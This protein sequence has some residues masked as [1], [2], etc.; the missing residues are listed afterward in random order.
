MLQKII[1]A[2]LLAA[3]VSCSSNTEQSDVNDT[4]SAAVDGSDEISDDSFSED[5]L[6]GNS[7]EEQTVE[8]ETD[9]IDAAEDNFESQETA[10]LD[11]AT[12]DEFSFDEDTNDSFSADNLNEEADAAA[13]S[14]A[15]LADDANTPSDSTD[16][17]SQE[18]EDYFAEDAGAGAGAVAATTDASGPKANVTKLDFLANQNGGTIVITT[19]N[20]V[21]YTTRSNPDSKQF[22]IEIPNANLPKKFQRPYNTNEFKGAIGLFQGYQNPDGNVA[23]FVVQMDKDGEPLVQQE[24]NS[25]MIIA[26]G[27]IASTDDGMSAPA[28]EMSAEVTATTDV[29]AEDQ[30]YASN[31]QAMSSK[32]IEDFLSGNT[33]F[34]GRK[35]NIEVKDWEIRDVFDFIAEQSGLNI[36]LAEEVQGKISLKLRE[37]PWDQALFVVMQSKQLG[38]KRQGNIV[39]VAPLASLRAETDAAK[40]VLDS[41]RLLQPMQVKIIP[42]SYAKARDLENQ[43][44]DFLTPS[45]GKAKADERTN[46][47]VITDI[48]EV[49]EKVMELVKNLDTETPQVLIE[50]KIVEAKESFSRNIGVNWQTGNNVTGSSGDVGSTVAAGLDTFIGSITFGKAGSGFLSTFRV[51]EKEDMLKVLS[52]PRILGLNNVTSKI[53]Q[54][55]DI[56]IQKTDNVNGSI[57]TTTTYIPVSLILEVTPQ[58]TSQGSV[59]MGLKLTREFVGAVEGDGRPIFKR[60]ANTTVVVN[61]G[62]TAVVGGIYQSDQRNLD[63]GVPLLSKIPVLG[64]LF[65]RESRDL[66][67]NELMMFVTPRIM[68]L[69]KAFAKDGAEE[70]LINEQNDFL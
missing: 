42:V 24:G 47:L 57:T 60:K 22:V 58:I 44:K 46:A 18:S 23:R 36:V 37:V 19:D 3:F 49:I 39:R 67:K 12:S 35:I 64:Y 2:L 20:P 31:D 45:R 61:N 4:A 53:E 38:Y 66:E 28:P 13:V 14:E 56:P 51:L 68:N 16:S 65:K 69:E 17:F 5:D 26:S 40:Q 50:A 63:E 52:S 6:L 32:N 33:E 70:E 9:S 7:T 11:E 59:I 1:L 25:I 54:T 41:Q 15:P 29:S 43:V 27:A 34:Y 62:E 21:T 10:D 55:S 8:A 48:P 30:S